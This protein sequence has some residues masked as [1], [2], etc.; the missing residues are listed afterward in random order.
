MKND[1]KSSINQKLTEIYNNVQTANNLPVNFL[2]GRFGVSLF[3]YHYANYSNQQSVKNYFATYLETTIGNLAEV[4]SVRYN[5]GFAGIGWAL[6]YF[7]KRDL[8]TDE[9]NGLFESIDEL[10]EENVEL[11]ATHNNF[12]FLHGMLGIGLYFLE[13]NKHEMIGYVVNAL[14]ES[15]TEVNDGCNW[16][17]HTYQGEDTTRYATY[18]FSM[19]HGCAGIMSFL[20]KCATKGEIYSNKAQVLLEKNVRFILSNKLEGMNS[21][22]PAHILLDNPQQRNPSRLAWCYGDLGMSAA[23]WQAGVALDSEAIRQEA[24]AVCLHASKRTE[25]WDTLVMDAGICH[26]TSGIA[27][28]FNRM[29]QQTKI[30]AFR[31]AANFWI[32]KTLEYGQTPDGIAGFKTYAGSQGGND[33]WIN[34]YS[35]LDG[36]S[37]IGLALISH[38]VEEDLNWDQSLLI[39]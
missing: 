38:L 8:F 18:N 6:S 24:V 36:V 26:G 31:E 29:F 34:D 1:L 37:G 23:L 15:A 28:I 12:D 22:F 19:P 7:Q 30:D 9:L 20:S 21:I 13:R 11:Y 10:L 17:S 35:L 39:S 33:N 5:D 32:D 25:D 4:Q 27:L 14:Q 2:G 16:L 3:I